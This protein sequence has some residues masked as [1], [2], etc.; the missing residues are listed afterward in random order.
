MKS[1]QGSHGVPVLCALLKMSSTGQLWPRA[2]K[3]GGSFEQETKE[4]RCKHTTVTREKIE[5]R[6]GFGV[7]SVRDRCFLRGKGEK[8]RLREQL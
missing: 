7:G 4:E 8:A 1:I 3:H 2:Q 5:V 6:H